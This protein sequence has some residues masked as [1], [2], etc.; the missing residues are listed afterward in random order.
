MV[1]EQIEV[2]RTAVEALLRTPSGVFNQYIQVDLDL[3]RPDA[4]ERRLA[5]LARYLEVFGAA[6][7]L[8]VGE[9]VGF[10]AGRFS[11][12]PFTDE[13]G[14]V[15]PAPLAWARAVGGFQRCSRDDRPLLREASAGVV[16]RALGDR[17]DVALWNVVPWHPAGRR[18]PLSNALPNR[19][20]YR[21]GLVVLRLMLE[22]FEFSKPACNF[23]VCGALTA[24]A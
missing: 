20:A 22:T 11:G 14:L 19:A 3:D 17:R 2:R 13:A 23:E 10:R 5:N 6:R 4:A 9:A 21:A 16:W 12:V 15:G 24:V 8:L 7:Y 18:G 1:Q